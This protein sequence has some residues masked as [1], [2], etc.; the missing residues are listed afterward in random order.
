M[1]IW[2]MMSTSVQKSDLKGLE[3]K[4]DDMGVAPSTPT[5]ILS[6]EG[7]EGDFMF[8][9]GQNVGYYLGVKYNYIIIFGLLY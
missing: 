4:Y 1:E 7:A 8:Q 5:Q 9:S 3:L 6:L 2:S